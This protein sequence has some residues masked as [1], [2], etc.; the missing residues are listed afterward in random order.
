MLSHCF[1]SGVVAADIA[2]NE[3]GDDFDFASLKSPLFKLSVT[4]KAE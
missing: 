4:F 2:D 1:E 3:D